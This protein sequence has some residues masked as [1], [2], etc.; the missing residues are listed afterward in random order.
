M[1]LYQLFRIIIVGKVVNNYSFLISTTVWSII[2]TKAN[3]YSIFDQ[4][5]HIFLWSF[6]K[7]HFLCK[8][9]GCFPWKKYVCSNNTLLPLTSLQMDL[10]AFTTNDNSPCIVYDISYVVWC[11]TCKME[12]GCNNDY[13]QVSKTKLVYGVVCLVHILLYLIFILWIN[14]SFNC[15]EYD[16][17]IQSHSNMNL[18]VW[19]LVETKEK[20]RGMFEIQKS[21]DKTSSG[22]IGPWT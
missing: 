18:S 5:D 11:L 10:S 16:F 8:M 6:Q 21:G 12:K 20:Y 13:I 7:C 14:Q 2:Q 3:L 15:H 17:M 19:V 22:E 1:T 4:T 9:H